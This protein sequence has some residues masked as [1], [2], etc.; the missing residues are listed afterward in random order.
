MVER[1]L[2]TCF[3]EAAFSP[4]QGILLYDGWDSSAHTEGK[5]QKSVRNIPCSEH[6]LIDA[7][8]ARCQSE[9]PHFRKKFVSFL[10]FLLASYIF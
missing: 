9:L 2:P 1:A 3:Q 10:I 8:K 6:Q 4:E 7:W 5:C